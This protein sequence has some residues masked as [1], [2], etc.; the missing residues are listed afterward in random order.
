M[1]FV[2]L[3]LFMSSIPVFSLGS[4]E[5]EDGF[6][7]PD[8]VEIENGVE[9][10]SENEDVEEIKLDSPPRL[11]TRVVPEY[12]ELL[13]NKKVQGFATLEFTILEDG[14]VG[15]VIVIQ[16]NEKL[17]GE[18]ASSALRQCVFTIP[19]V[20]GVPTRAKLTMTMPFRLTD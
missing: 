9:N 7:V 1:K 5:K 17:F 18:A 11:I 2:L 4:S 14:K 13:K 19:K 3:I 8:G 12:P 6:K 16:T 15:D 20:D 10:S